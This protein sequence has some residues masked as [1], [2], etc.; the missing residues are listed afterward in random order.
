[1]LIREI[2]SVG[3][4]SP[5]GKIQAID[6][7]IPG[8]VIFA[9][10]SS[11]GGYWIGADLFRTLP[12][13]AQR[14][15]HSTGGWFEEDCDAA[16]PFAFLPEMGNDDSKTRA[17]EAILHSSWYLPSVREA[18]EKQIDLEDWRRERGMGA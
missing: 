3:G 5:W 9:S 1:M 8:R 11:H 2:P 10:T 16:I 6:V 14:T 4:A 17:R 12:T 15:P 18:L 13:C 7:V